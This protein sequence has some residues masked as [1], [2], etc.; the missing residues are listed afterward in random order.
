MGDRAATRSRRI[1]SILLRCYPASFRARYGAELREAFDAERAAGTPP[2]RFWIRILNDLAV[3][4]A[5]IR[6]GR[7][8]TL[9]PDRQ[10]QA[11][12]GVS[13]MDTLVHDLR[14]AVRLLRRR[15]GFSA[16]AVLS[17][18]LGI[19]ANSLIFSL[20]DGLVLH[21]FRYPDPD[22]LL[23]IGVSFPRLS[24]DETFV[25]ALSPAEY[26]DIKQARSFS[27]TTA[28]DLGNRNISGGDRPERVFT[29]LA[30]DDPFPA[31]GMPPHLGRGFTAQELAEGGPPA[32]VISHRVW[33]SRFGAD[34][35]IVGKIIRMNGTPTAVVGV[36]PPGLLLI[37]TDLWIPWGGDP[38]RLPRHVRQFTILARLKPDVTLEQARAEL[39]TIAARVESEH[40]QQLKEYAG[41][42]LVPEPWAAALTRPLRL[43]G[44]VLLAAVGFVL[45]IACANLANLLLA[46]GAARQTEIAVRLAL[47]AGRWRVVRLLL[48]E[49]ILLGLAGAA[50]GLSI[51]YLGLDLVVPLLP[52][53]VAMLDPDIRVSGRVIAYC[54]GLALLSGAFVGLL[55]AL[56]VARFDPHSALKAESRSATAGR[57]ARRLR[58]GLIVS[59]VA[60]ALV[61]LAGAGL[62]MR[63][64]LRIQQ[65]DPGF[66]P[67]RVLTMRV[68]LP[69][70]KYEDEAITAFF[71]RLAGSVREL[72][73][74]RAV[75]VASQYPPQGGFGSQ[76]RIEGRAVPQDGA[77][78]RANYTI[79]DPGFFATLGV[80][81]RQG[82]L[83]GDRDLAESPPVVVVNETFASRFFGRESAL[84]RRVK[85]GG[86]DSKS[87]WAEI[88]GIVRD[89]RNEGL[90]SP[91]APEVF[92]PLRQVRGWW[93]QLF[94]LVRTEGDAM[95][96]LPGVREQIRAIDPDQP[97]YAI[98]TLEE[99]LAASLFQQRVAM[100][101]LLVF[102]GVAIALA[103]IGVYGVMSYAVSARTQEI[104]I[105]MALGASARDVRWLIARQAVSLLVVGLAIGTA[106]SLALG[107]AMAGLLYQTTPSDPLTLTL[108]GGV[109][110]LVGLTA[111]YLPAMRASNVDPMLALRYE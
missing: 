33:Q 39:A 32:A 45:L 9:V 110:A 51:A 80:G 92:L 4:S 27:R 60:L 95:A 31:I 81:V 29:L 37:G 102:A 38:A 30:L 99:A 22:R 55:P 2:I 86:A 57:V 72:P 7:R 76:I 52:A 1:Y 63:S 50:A 106:L 104:G 58:Q 108:V 73:G 70:Q 101:L 66:D 98:A 10:P 35:A 12:R 19:G 44:F 64:F 97:V 65:V 105:R 16:A 3:S 26:A 83:F 40:G 47:G 94:V 85:I 54:A 21:P 88:V 96:L 56:Q 14:Y 42:R 36:M 62:L 77:L 5:R 84:A 53:E 43:A 46:R 59:E 25:E 107:R 93:N 69:P 15:R 79:A 61:L 24:A 100:V 91:V 103:A 13:H 8:D 28:F 82:R 109:L 20:V 87:P 111:G 18:A 6:L 71:E 23:G 78:P 67:S 68:T 48:T 90:T 11:R 49:T 41:W 74:V 34:P 17:L 89:T 75:G